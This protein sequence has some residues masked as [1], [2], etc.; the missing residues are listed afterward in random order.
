MRNSYFVTEEKSPIDSRTNGSVLDREVCS[1]L[2]RPWPPLEVAPSSQLYYSVVST[3]GPGLPKPT[4]KQSIIRLRCLLRDEGR[5]D[6]RRGR[7]K[8]GSA[9][10]LVMKKGEALAELSQG[11]IEHMSTSSAVA[12][13]PK[14][15][16]LCLLLVVR[17]FFSLCSFLSG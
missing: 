1:A 7:G 10:L 16:R 8:L 17:I 14:E 9:P 5:Q 12:C 15:K 3:L 11:K 4:E 13:H 2:K 6:T